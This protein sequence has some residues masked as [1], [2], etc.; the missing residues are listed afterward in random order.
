[1]RHDLVLSAIH[2]CSISAPEYVAV[3]DRQRVVTY[4]QLDLRA[5]QLARQLRELGA[6]RDALVGVML[7]RSPELIVAALGALYAGA[8]YLP[9]DTGYPAERIAFMLQ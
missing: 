9:L 5:R 4:E 7:D 1:M 2:A 6:G 3:T 8:A